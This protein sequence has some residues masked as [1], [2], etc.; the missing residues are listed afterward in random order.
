MT[1]TPVLPFYTFEEFLQDGSYT[2]A[3]LANSAHLTYFK[4]SNNPVLKK[5]YHKLIAPHESSLPPH[6][7]PLIANV[8]VYPKYA[9][10]MIDKVVLEQSAKLNCS[11]TKVHGTSMKSTWS[12]IIRKRDP[13]T[14]ILIHTLHNMLRSGILQALEKRT[15][16]SENLDTQEEIRSVTIIQVAPILVALIAGL[17]LSIL[18]L[19]IAKGIQSVKSMHWSI[20]IE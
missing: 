9:I 19:I 4:K 12:F 15:L 20:D 16:P 17:S 11:L 6:Y 8:C 14:G 1:S 10:R 13:Y 7:I 18:L 3:V 5:I 2:L